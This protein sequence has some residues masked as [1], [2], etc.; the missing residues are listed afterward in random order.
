MSVP[1]AGVIGFPV[2]HSLSPDIFRA[3]SAALARP[4]RYRTLALRPERL[5]EAL[6]KARSRRWI[7][8]NVTLPHKV[9]VMGHLDETDPTA[10]EVGAVNVVR[11]QD[12]RR[13]G[14]N[15][16]VE[17]F[18]APLARRGVELRGARAVVLGAGGAARAVC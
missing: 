15:T 18:L 16:D 4:L 10:R 6:G 14:Y 5:G 13:M 7:G 11:F 12:G 9:A 2:R 17:G 8:W 1:W 3:F